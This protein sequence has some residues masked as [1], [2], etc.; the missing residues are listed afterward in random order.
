MHRGDARDAGLARFSAGMQ[1]PTGRESSSAGMRVPVLEWGARHREPRRREP[2][3]C[4]GMRAQA[5]RWKEELAGREPRRST[6]VVGTVNGLGWVRKKKWGFI[7]NFLFFNWADNYG[8]LPPQQ[9][10]LFFATSSTQARPT[11]QKSCQFVCRSSFARIAK[12]HP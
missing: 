6:A 2:C 4:A 11:C 3:R 1:A 12:N 10:A 5:T 9:M 8:P 7:L